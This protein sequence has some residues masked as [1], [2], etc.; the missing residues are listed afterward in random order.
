YSVL[1][2]IEAVKR[3][4]G[5]DFEVRTTGR[6]PGDPAQIIAA[7]DKLRGRLSWTPAL[8]DLDGIV[9]DALAWERHLAQRNAP[10]V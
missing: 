8:D 1:Q 9:R 2:V 4:S 10:L 7:S 3:A 6:R 5:R